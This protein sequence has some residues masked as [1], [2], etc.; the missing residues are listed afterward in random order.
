MADAGMGAFDSAQ[1]TFGFKATADG[2]ITLGNT[3]DDEIQ[4]T[5]SLTVNGDIKVNQYIYHNG[6]GNT[7]IN[8]A[9]DKIIL[10]AGGK[11]MVTMEEKNSAPHEVT[12][13][14]GG[15]NVDFVVKGNGSNAGNPAFKVDASNNRVGIN[16]VG[17]PSVELDVSGDVNF[18]GAAV[19]NESSADKDFRVESNH[20]THMFYIDG[21][22][23]RLG[24]GT[25]SPQVL[26]DVRDPFDGIAGHESDAVLRLASKK[27]VGIKLCADTDNVEETDNP[28]VDFYSDGN[29]DTQGR[30]NRKGSL[31]IEGA[32]GTTF[33][34]SL[35]NAFFMNAV[36]P[37]SLNTSRPL[38]I[39]NASV[40]DGNKA[41]ITLEGSHG[42]VGIHTTTP[43]TP[44]E[45]VGTTMSTTYATDPTTQDLGNGTSSTL[46]ISSGLMFL[47]ADS[48]TSAD[49][50]GGFMA[51]TLT[52]PNGTTS[53]Q[54]LTLVIEG[55]MGAGNNV[56]IM[57]A[58]SLMGAYDVFMPS[59]KTSINFVYYSTAA[60]SAWYQV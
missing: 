13:N 60:I 54:R 46:S 57:I 59:A 50:G 53:G 14:D 18:D 32:A 39:A 41:R 6:D 17:E 2:K 9:E 7:L 35:A 33:T 27:S 38:Q 12:I 11:A 31:A 16:G 40:A 37:L 45:I 26:L 20:H 19:F 25:N 5:G 43:T 8:F 15:N 58:G 48:I 34:D 1:G 4:V 10:K 42:Y 28:Y 44:L 52:L 55:N 47:D 36:Y 49:I 51:H 56:P 23:N 3:A 29:A 24:V 21:G 30:S 22:S